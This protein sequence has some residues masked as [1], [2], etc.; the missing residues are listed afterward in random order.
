MGSTKSPLSKK[1]KKKTTRPERSNCL[2]AK[3]SEQKGP[4]GLWA[5]AGRT[6]E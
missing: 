1:K 4:T 5:A 3:M 6:P 2:K